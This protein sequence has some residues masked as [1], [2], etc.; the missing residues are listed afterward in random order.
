MEISTSVSVTDPVLEWEPLRIDAK[1][2]AYRR[3]KI[4]AC[5]Y[6]ERDLCKFCK[7]LRF[8]AHVNY[9]RQ[10]RCSIEEHGNNFSNHRKSRIQF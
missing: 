10:N 8:V 6:G 3:L 4:K 5:R 1:K 2:H 7:L 9:Y